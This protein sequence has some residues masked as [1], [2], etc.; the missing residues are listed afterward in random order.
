MSKDLTDRDQ[1]RALT[2]Q[3]PG[4][5]VPEPMRPHARKTGPQARPFDDVAHQVG[6]DRSARCP[7][8]QE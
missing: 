5:G 3:L 7:A 4:Q 1:A 2:Q 6:A 8:C